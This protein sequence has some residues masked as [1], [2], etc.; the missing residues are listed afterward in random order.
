MM[1]NFYGKDF[2]ELIKEI[3]KDYNYTYAPQL[4]EYE[5]KAKERYE[6]EKNFETEELK[7]YP[8]DSE[9]IRLIINERYSKMQYSSIDYDDSEEKK[10]LLK[11]RR[12]VEEFFKKELNCD[13][14][15]DPFYEKYVKYCENSGNKNLIMSKYEIKEE[16]QKIGFGVNIIYNDNDEPEKYI[17]F[18][19]FTGS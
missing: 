14:L 9:Y 17:T 1:N 3:S 2:F 18:R 11:K 10:E 12:I 8:I 13:I 5:E 16:M 19:F 6:N 7:K 4:I 15:F